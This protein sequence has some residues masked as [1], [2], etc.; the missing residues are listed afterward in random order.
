VVTGTELLSGRITDRNGPWLAQRLD[1][2]GVEVAHLLCVGDRPAD[3]AAALRFLASQR[4]DLVITSGGLGPT[5]D[6]LTAEVVAGFAGV[7]LELDE[8]LEQQITAILARFSHLARFSPEALQ[9]ANRKQAMVPRG[10][11]PLDPVG[12][13]PGLVIPVAGGP[14]VIVLPGPPRELQAMWPAAL[15]TSATRT[16]LARTRPFDS[17]RLRLFG[18][19]ESELAATLREVSATLD[20]TPLEITTCLRQAELEIDIRHRPGAEA[21]RDALV[22]AIRARHTRYLFS[23]DGSSLDDQLA[24]LL[25]GRRIGFGESCTGG[26]LAARLTE[27]PGASDYVAGGVVAYSNTAKTKVLGVT[28]ELIKRHGA[29][30]PQVARAMADGARNRFGADIGCGITGVAGPGGGTDAKPVGYV[31]LCVSTSDGAAL[32]SD[33]VLPGDRAE[34]RDRSVAAAMH[35]IRRVLTGARR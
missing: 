31:C 2:L 6:D 5:A 35:L 19:P 16:V 8:A 14:T 15:A 9:V 29:V 23:T 10:A 18:L 30:S 4:V 25:R 21:I 22:E 28:A 24:N 3:L 1:E 20:L 12:T 13:A 32:A 33:P 27:R 34:I 7:E 17:A 11:Q 26:L